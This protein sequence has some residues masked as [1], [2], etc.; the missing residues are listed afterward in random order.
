MHLIYTIPVE[1]D[2][3]PQVESNHHHF[4]RR[5]GFYALNYGANKKESRHAPPEQPNRMT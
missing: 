3:Q 1:K 4:F 5:E 2:L